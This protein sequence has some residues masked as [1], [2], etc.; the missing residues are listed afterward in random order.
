MIALFQV[1]MSILSRFL[2][3]NDLEARSIRR[4][5]NSLVSD[6]EFRFS[7][8]LLEHVAALAPLTLVLPVE[9]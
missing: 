9:I 8:P 6:A 2:K 3:G 4:V 5:V 7:I 1:F